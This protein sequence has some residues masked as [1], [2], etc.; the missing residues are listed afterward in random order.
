M[1]LFTQAECALYLEQ[2]VGRVVS[3][4]ITYMKQITV[5]FHKRSIF[6]RSAIVLLFS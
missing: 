3:S 6:C 1:I 4:V 2:F 5:T